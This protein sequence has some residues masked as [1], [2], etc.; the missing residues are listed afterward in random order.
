MAKIINLLPKAR[1]Q[2]LHFDSMLHSLWLVVIWSVLS[3]AAVFLAQFGTKFYLQLQS[4]NIHDQIQAL[5]A[6]VDK[7]QNADVK[8]KVQ[9]VNNLIG[10]YH[11]LVVAAPQWSKIV[12][13]FLPLPPQNVKINALNINVQ[14]KSISITG[15]SPSRE[16]VIQLYN[17]ILSDKKDFYGVDYPL[18]NVVTPTDNAF[19]FTFFVQDKLWKQ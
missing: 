9:E 16:L 8:T 15:L 4:R 5:Q 18:E 14:N 3:F 13:A 7:Q 11:N 6:E 2:E 10:D 19:H 17:N 1:Q 12:K